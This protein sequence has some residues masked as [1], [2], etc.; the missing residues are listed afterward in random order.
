MYFLTEDQGQL[1]NYDYQQGDEMYDV[2]G[3]EDGPNED[4]GGE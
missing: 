3:T 4:G 2:D 1:E